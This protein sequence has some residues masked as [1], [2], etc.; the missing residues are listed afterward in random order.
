MRAHLA[1]HCEPATSWGPEQAAKYVICLWTSNVIYSNPC[2]K[3]PC[4]GILTYQWYTQRYFTVNSLYSSNICEI[5]LYNWQLVVLFI[6]LYALFVL[7]ARGKN[8]REKRLFFNS[9]SSLV[10]H[11]KLGIKLARLSKLQINA[12]RVIA[13]SQLNAHTEPLLGH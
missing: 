1:V 8:Y 13:W 7:T 11:L 6:S 10:C 5:L 3:H 12:I 9:P 4:R 2:S